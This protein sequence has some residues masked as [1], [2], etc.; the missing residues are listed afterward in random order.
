MKK[1]RYLGIYA[2][3]LGAFCIVLA[4]LMLIELER[5]TLFSNSKLQGYAIIL[6]GVVALFVFP[7]SIVAGLKE[8]GYGVRC[9]R[10]KESQSA[11]NQK[12]L[13][14]LGSLVFLVF[15]ILWTVE[16][17]RYVFGGCMFAISVALT[18]QYFI[19]RKK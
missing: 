11:R 1:K 14:L 13:I 8:M 2:L 15:G 17:C 5:G 12:L 6:V 16:F 4:L 9:L 3:V 19:E 10:K 18:T 7:L